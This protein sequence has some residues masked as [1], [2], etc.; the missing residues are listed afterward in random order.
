ME[1]HSDRRVAV[2]GGEIGRKRQ[3]GDVSA[4]MLT[5]LQDQRTARRE[6][7]GG[8]TENH[9]VGVKP[10]VATV[11]RAVWI[12]VADFSRQRVDV[13][14]RNIR[15]FETIRSKGPA[16]AAAK[17]PPKRLRARSAPSALRWTVRSVMRRN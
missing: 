3:P 12:M 15:G 5:D 4:L 11:E 14:A 8:L 6:Q 17:L 13:F 9:P 2:R 10:V 16:R 7:T 1:R